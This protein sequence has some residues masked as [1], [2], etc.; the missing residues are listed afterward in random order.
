MRRSVDMSHHPWIMS[1]SDSCFVKSPVYQ[2]SIDGLLLDG[3]C[4]NDW[5]TV[6][7]VQFD[8]VPRD[9]GERDVKMDYNA[10]NGF[11]LQEGNYGRFEHFSVRAVNTEG[12]FPICQPFSQNLYQ[13]GPQR[14]TIALLHDFLKPAT[15]GVRSLRGVQ[16]TEIRRTIE[17]KG[18]VRILSIKER[19]DS[20][21][22]NTDKDAFKDTAA[23][24][25]LG[26][27]EHAKCI[28]WM[29]TVN[30]APDCT[31][32][33]EG[34]GNPKKLAAAE[35]CPGVDIPDQDL[36]KRKRSAPTFFSEDDAGIRKRRARKGS[37]SVVP[38]GPGD[39]RNALASIHE[40]AAYLAKFVEPGCP[41]EDG[42]L[43]FEKL[44]VRARAI[45]R[46]CRNVLRKID[47]K[48]K[49]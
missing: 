17:L 37:A 40:D 27:V 4:A 20:F 42:N 10:G 32:S 34:V 38:M 26:K 46:Q 35:R 44:V 15:I 45:L 9:A 43:A 24:R 13:H 25:L 23:Y 1:Q 28:D 21:A 16:N 12:I 29:F 39:L 31:D 30:G 41:A 14:T 2:L 36:G 49:V 33:G 11:V 8:Y 5:G 6:A 7:T 22:L 3:F 19:G 47:A 48:A 18:V